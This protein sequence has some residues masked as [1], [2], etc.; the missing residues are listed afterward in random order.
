[1]YRSTGAPRQVVLRVRP[2]TD[3]DL[4]QVLDIGRAVFPDF[5]ETPEEYREFEARLGVGGYT[6][7]HTVAETESGLV[8]GH[9]RFHHMP[10]Q[11]R[12]T[13]YHVAIFVRPDW[14]GRGVGRALYAHAL[15]D[16][17]ARGARELQSFA[18]ETMPEAVAFLERR[19]FRATMRTWETRLDLARFDPAPFARYLDR[20]R[21]AGVTVTTLANERA[22]DTG[23]LRRA[24]ALHNAVLADIPSPIPFTPPSFEHFLKSRVESVR[25][26]LDA[27]FLAKVGDEY[28]GEANVERPAIG[29]HLVHNVTGVLP[30]YRGRGIA[31]ALKLA[32]IAYGRA[33]GY[34]EIRTW[35]DSRNTGM[36]A[37]NDRLGFVRQPAWLT[38]EAVL[39]PEAA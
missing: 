1:M 21:E 8:V 30:A 33:R 9:C 25:A 35:N 2:A 15:T 7:V 36:L 31:M 5:Q 14:Q 22:H 19:G 3:A 20:A 32:T 16:L 28:V 11:F 26:L 24:Y 10:G 34:A 6:N 18:R 29:A 4:P 17:S 37:I 23:A 39:S 12:P 13:R 27:Y 38:F